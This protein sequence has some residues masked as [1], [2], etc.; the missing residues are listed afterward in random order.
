[1]KKITTTLLLFLTPLLAQAATYEITT[2]G[3]NLYFGGNVGVG[4][5]SPSQALDVVG[6]VRST[7]GFVAGIGTATI[8]GSG[9]NILLAQSA[10][11]VGIGSSNPGTSLDVQGSLRL[12]GVGHGIVFQ[13]GTSQLTAASGSG[14]S[15]TVNSGTS[16]NIAYYASSTNAVSTNSNVQIIGANVGIGTDGSPDYTLEITAASG[17]PAFGISSTASTSGDWVTV[18]ST[19]NVG[20]GSPTPGQLL[21]IEGGNVGIGTHTAGAPLVVTGSGATGITTSGNVGIGT[22]IPPQALY[23]VGAIQNTGAMIVS[24]ITSDSG[25]TDATICEDTTVHQ[26]YSGSGTLGICLGTSSARYK[27]DINSL[28][29]GLNEILKL[30]PVTFYYKNGYGDN[31][32]RLQ[33]GLI[34]EDVRSIV[35]NLVALDDKG[36]PNSVDL[37][38]MTPILINAVREQQNEIKVIGVILLVL[39]ILIFILR[40]K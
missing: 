16:G 35:P 1:M 2:P 37:L 38:G 26:L 27:H 4:S 30:K 17:T 39:F 6:T 11:N 5:S 10:G 9:A 29:L 19:G 28:G 34:A 8:T 23:V 33:Y 22:T 7:L 31:G 36:E 15:G 12:N 3:N 21:D 18:S 40:K 25:K 14:G 32:A 24:G 20:I 13:D